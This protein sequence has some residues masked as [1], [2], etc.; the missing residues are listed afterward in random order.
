VPG[1]PNLTGFQTPSHNWLG[2]CWDRSWVVLAEPFH[3]RLARSGAKVALQAE[4]AGREVE[5]SCFG[6]ALSWLRLHVLRPS[7]ATPESFDWKEILHKQ[8]GSA[9]AMPGC[10][11]VWVES[12]NLGELAEVE[13]EAVEAQELAGTGA[14]RL[15][16]T[17]DDSRS[18][19]AVSHTQEEV[20]EACDGQG[21][22]QSGTE[23]AQN[24]GADAPPHLGVGA[25]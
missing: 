5:D 25:I 19:E 1:T 16:S 3:A 15:L 9:V 14:R 10:L 23:L 8:G 6:E 22:R 21:S 2:T 17:A 4:A 24:Y 11:T 18:R 12:D 7:R 20:A 13:G